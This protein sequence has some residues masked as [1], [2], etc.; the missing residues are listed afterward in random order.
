LIISYSEVTQVVL[1]VWIV[2]GDKAFDTNRI[3][4]SLIILD[5]WRASAL[6]LRVFATQHHHKYGQ[7]KRWIMSSKLISAY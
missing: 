7:F 6:P 1:E 4:Q 3:A 5:S 2:G